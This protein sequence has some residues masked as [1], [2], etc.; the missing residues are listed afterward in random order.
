MMFSLLFATGIH[1][2]TDARMM[3]SRLK[4]AKIEMQTADQPN[5]NNKKEETNQPICLHM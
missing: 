5:L 4:C 3:K 1:I 2:I